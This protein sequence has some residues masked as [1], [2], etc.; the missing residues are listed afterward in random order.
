MKLYFYGNSRRNSAQAHAGTRLFSR[1]IYRLGR[2]EHK[3]LKKKKRGAGDKQRMHESSVINCH[4]GSNYDGVEH[5]QQV[6]ANIDRP[7]VA[8]A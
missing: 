8:I 1:H 4:P 2:V 7:H 3:L 5:T 6:A